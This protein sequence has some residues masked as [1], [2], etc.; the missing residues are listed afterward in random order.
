MAVSTATWPKAVWVTDV[1]LKILHK[2]KL[3]SRFSSLS[4]IQSG[5]NSMVRISRCQL[6]SSAPSK[7]P[8]GRYL[9]KGEA[10]GLYTRDRYHLWT[11]MLQDKQWY[12]LQMTEIPR[13]P[14]T[15]AH[16]SA[17]RVIVVSLVSAREV[18]APALDLCAP[19]NPTAK[20]SRFLSQPLHP[21]PEKVLGGKRKST[22][23]TRPWLASKFFPRCPT[24]FQGNPRE[25]W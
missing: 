21:G 4:T 16:S 1:T 25:K 9:T 14:Y 6:P 15:A 3:S 22:A 18:S 8:W 5:S 17:N 2:A 13:A 19:K 7:W 23:G 10:S 20:R 12:P 11:G 24:T